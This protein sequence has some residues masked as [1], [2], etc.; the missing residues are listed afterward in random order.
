MKD[1][2]TYQAS[3]LEG[4]ILNANERTTNVD[5]KVLDKICERIRKADLN[6]YPDDGCKRLKKIYADSIGKEAACVLAGNGSDQMLGLMI[7]LFTGKGRPLAVIDP[8]FSMYDYYAGMQEAE[9]KKY[10]SLDEMKNSS[11]GLFVFSNPNNPTGKVIDRD[12]VLA[13]CDAVAPAPVIVDEAYMDFGDE[14]VLNDI[15]AHKNL[16]VTRTLSKAYGAAGIRCGFLVS[17][18]ENI[19]QIE[20]Y[21]VPY[22]V[23]VLDQIAAE[24][25]LEAGRPYLEEVRQERDRMFEALNGLPVFPSG[26]NFLF[27]KGE[28]MAE[29]GQYLASSGIHVRT[30]PGKDQI[31]I[32]IGTPAE[33]DQVISVINNWRKDHAHR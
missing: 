11:A 5:E 4:I 24:A 10:A 31:R 13:F 14:S 20:P 30:W 28:C 21:H 23:S 18:K 26:A 15:E 33:N 17:S 29:L 1:V 9:V 8:D 12:T 32:T 19:G 7:Q 22:S 2:E 6:R 3:Q 27:L 16:Y 25:V